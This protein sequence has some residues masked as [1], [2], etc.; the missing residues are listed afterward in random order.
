[1]KEMRIRGVP[2]DLHREFKIL[3]TKNDMSMN[4]Y[5]IKLMKE[6]LERRKKT[7]DKKGKKGTL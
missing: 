3:C 1:M 6:E 4:E 2:D 7:V 5:L